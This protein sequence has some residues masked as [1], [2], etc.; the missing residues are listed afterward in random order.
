MRHDLAKLDELRLANFGIVDSP[1]FCLEVSVDST[2]AL[3]AALK[4]HGQNALPAKSIALPHSPCRRAGGEVVKLR[5]CPHAPSRGGA[6]KCEQSALGTE[7]AALDAD[8]DP[9]GLQRQG[10][11]IDR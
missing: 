4:L 8:W 3:F 5:R 1:I 2:D 10:E 11:T 6:N 9:I 7:A